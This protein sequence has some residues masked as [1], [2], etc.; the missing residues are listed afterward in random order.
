MHT[1]LV[2]AIGAAVAA[3]FLI[4]FGYKIGQA[5]SDV[6]HAVEHIHLEG[7]SARP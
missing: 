1:L 3:P 2:A 7:M 5:S 4:A 6:A